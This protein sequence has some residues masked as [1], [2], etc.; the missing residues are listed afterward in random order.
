ML[1][2]ATTTV[3]TSPPRTAGADDDG[4]R[5]L[6]D[7]TW[8]RWML[9]GNVIGAGVMAVTTLI[10]PDTTAS[11]VGLDGDPLLWR[12]VGSMWLGFATAS[13]IGLT[14]PVRYRA[15]MVCQTIYKSMFV[16]LAAPAALSNSGLATLVVGFV[17]LIAGYGY[18][19][20]TSV[21]AVQ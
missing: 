9:W 19:L 17:A 12:L 3:D 1:R 11:L 5:R 10:S 14:R 20:R 21:D 2:S 7:L 8:T 6:N 18:A 16:A 15:V 4:R 13:A